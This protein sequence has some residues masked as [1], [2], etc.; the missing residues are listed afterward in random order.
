MN[1]NKIF[2]WLLTFC[3]IQN[4]A[5]VSAQTYGFQVLNGTKL[6][7]EAGTT[8]TLVNSLGVKV[9]GLGSSITNNGTLAMEGDLLNQN[10]GS[11]QNGLY[12]VGGSLTTITG[13]WG[14]NTTVEFNGNT[15]AAT[16]NTIWGMNNVT[17]NKGA[18]FP[19]VNLAS[20]ADIA[21]VLTFTSG[22]LQTN[23]F[24]VAITATGSITG[25]DA[26]KFIITNSSGVLR[27]NVSFSTI[28]YPIGT[29]NGSYT[30]LSIK[31]NAGSVT[32]NIRV[33]DQV[34]N[35]GTSGSPLN[36][37]VV[38]KTWTITESGAP[39]T[40]KLDL[41]AQWNS[42]NELSLDGNRCGIS[43]WNPTTSAWD[44]AWADVGAR[45][46]SD[47]YTRSRSNITEVGTFAVGSK[48]VA[49][50]VQLSAKV[51]LQGAYASNSLMNE[52]LRSLSLIPSAENTTAP[53]GQMPRPN[54]YTHTAWGGSET[55]ASGAFNVQT[56][57]NDNIVDWVFVEL[58]DPSVSATILHTRAALLQKDGD[59]VNENGTSPLKIYGVPDGNYYIS[60]RHRN[61]LAVRSATTKS[62]SRAANTTVDFT[63]NLSEA[64]ATPNGT[65]YNA[66]ATMSDGKYAL[67]GGNVNSDG[68]VRRTGSA[69]TNDVSLFLSYM[70]SNTSLPTVYRRE[71][72]NMNGTVQRV[73]SASANDVSRILSFLGSN[74]II[75]QPIF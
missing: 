67:W 47:P 71:D 54:G 6:Y 9:D 16:L 62:L 8:L 26:T 50:Y 3:M 65:A 14:A 40:K 43:R 42:S 23:N 52:G 19:V 44:L 31:Q 69:S 56:N 70:G 61:H 55:A 34:L 35:N 58:R 63:L 13:S 15:N 27:Q 28:T 46:G 36:A 49:T 18:A 4:M 11:V 7:V 37:S 75:T 30:P 29:A 12:K 10:D 5:G 72:I 39:V 60:I 21:G 74:S 17:I 66:L 38:N 59:I 24:S 45:S 64:L 22:Y 48:P 32:L 25:Y 41:T 73:G 68:S 57:T 51:F 20:S 33:Q 53:S 2:V 1:K